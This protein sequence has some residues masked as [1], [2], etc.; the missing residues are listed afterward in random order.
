MCV[1]GKELSQFW[2]KNFSLKFSTL[3]NPNSGLIFFILR[4]V[5]LQQRLQTLCGGVLL[6]ADG[7]G[8]AAGGAVISAFSGTNASFHPS[9]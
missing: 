2:S 5:P 3:L 9:V 8:A 7:Q 1:L 6:A 4:P